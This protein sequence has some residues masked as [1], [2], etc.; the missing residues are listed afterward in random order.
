MEIDNEER[1]DIVRIITS[2]GFQ[3]GDEDNHSFI[4]TGKNLSAFIKFHSYLKVE[5][6]FDIYI[7]GKF[8]HENYP[9]ANL[10]ELVNKLHKFHNAIVHLEI[11]LDF[12]FSN[13][14][15]GY[16]IPNSI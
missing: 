15:F 1:K 3:N 12:L 16:T 13:N 9:V 8:W 6:N 5:L 7:K 10:D 11:G 2:Y 14:Q 4:Y